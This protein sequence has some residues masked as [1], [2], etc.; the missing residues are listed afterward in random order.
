MFSIKKGF[1]FLFHKT[2]DWFL[3]NIK[4]HFRLDSQMVSIS[5]AGSGKYIQVIQYDS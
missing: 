2:Q 4:H 1:V 5:F 3:C